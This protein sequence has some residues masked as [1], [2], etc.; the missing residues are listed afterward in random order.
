MKRS[1]P[2]QRKTRLRARRSKPEVRIGK[3]SGKIRLSGAAI[4]NLRIDCWEAHPWCCECGVKTLL[5][6]LSDANPQKMDMAHIVSRG[7]G[8]SDTLEN[9]RTLCHK[10]HM[11]EHAKGRA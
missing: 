10:C 11:Q 6:P 7:A 8:G 4:R 2:L 5:Y 3:V 1:A 9:V